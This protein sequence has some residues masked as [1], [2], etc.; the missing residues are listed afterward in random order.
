MNKVEKVDLHTPPDIE[1]FNFFHHKSA[2]LGTGVNAPLRRGGARHHSEPPAG[3]QHS[4]PPAININLPPEAFQFP[5]HFPDQ[6][7]RKRSLSV[8][9][10]SEFELRPDQE[11]DGIIPTVQQWLE[12][13]QTQGLAYNR[14]DIL[15]SRF[16][17]EGCLD[18]PLTTIAR[19][20]H[21][22]LKDGYDLRMVDMFLVTEQLEVAGKR[23]GFQVKSS[24]GQHRESKKRKP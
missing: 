19:L 12:E 4:M 11:A 1:Y 14:W 24:G 18:V 8:S 23:Y 9:S 20:S 17:A 22:M 6:R 13:L 5:R 10:S 15:Q 3:L 16:D 7:D 21:T 2:L